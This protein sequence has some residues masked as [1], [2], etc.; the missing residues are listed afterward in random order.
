VR[1]DRLLKLNRLGRPGSDADMISSSALEYSDS[2]RI[3]I[4][5][6][7]ASHAGTAPDSTSRTTTGT[8]LLPRLRA[9]ST[10][11]QHADDATESGLKKKTTSNSSTS[12]SSPACCASWYPKTETSRAAKAYDNHRTTSRSA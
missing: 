4:H 2:S 1:G 5:R 3:E 9:E 7:A 10:H 6:S 11:S 12:G 8:T